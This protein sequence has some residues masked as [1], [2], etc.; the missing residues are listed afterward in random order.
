[1]S[2]ERYANPE[3]AEKIKQAREEL[4]STGTGGSGDGSPPDVSPGE[5]RAA[6]REL[7]REDAPDAENPRPDLRVTETLEF[8]GHSFAFHEL[9][10]QELEAAQ[11]SD[12]DEGDVEQGS[13]AGQYVYETLGAAGVDTD[14]AYWRQYDLQASGDTDGVMDLFNAVVQAFNEDVDVEQLEAAGNS[15]TARED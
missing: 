10:D 3:T 11:F 15:R 4:D 2:T 7:A 9:G 1:M 8:R 6:E 14:E 13:K 5:A 12:I